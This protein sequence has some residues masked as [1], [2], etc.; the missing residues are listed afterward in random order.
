MIIYPP[1]PTA[2]ICG[3]MVVVADGF[4][5]QA[6]LEVQATLLIHIPNLFFTMLFGSYF[7]DWDSQDNFL[8]APLAQGLTLTNAGVEAA[9]GVSSNGHGRNHWLLCTGYTK[10]IMQLIL[11]AMEH[12]LSASV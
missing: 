7:G 9:L 8:R 4:K 12:V 3:R 1:W 10:I 11:Q 2:I 5:A 6:V